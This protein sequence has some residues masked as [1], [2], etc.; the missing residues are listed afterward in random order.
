MVGRLFAI[1]VGV[2]CGLALAQF[3]EFAQQYSQRLGGRLDELR[4]F[5]QRFDADA[6]RAGLT[7]AE[8]LAEF[9]RP[10]SAFLR[11]RGADAAVMIRRFEA[12]DA[13]KTA[14]DTA[15]PFE[16]LAVFLRT[17]DREVGQ[18]TYADFRPAVPVTAEG[19]VHAGAGFLGGVLAAS[20]I[21]GLGRGRRRSRSGG[22]PA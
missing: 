2:V 6:A 12:F 20:L 7:R 9:V 17:Y 4:G 13:A 18:A 1:A 15:A 21:F 11:D 5:V 14:L 3:P 22:A 16:R 8:G 10:G 19:A